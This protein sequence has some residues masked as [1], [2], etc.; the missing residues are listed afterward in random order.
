MF[1]VFCVY[2]PS[3]KP[4]E[5]QQTGHLHF[6]FFSANTPPGRARAVQ[7]LHSPCCRGCDR[8]GLLWQDK[9]FVRLLVAGAGCFQMKD[10]NSHIA[11]LIQAIVS[12]SP[13]SL[14]VSEQFILGS[15]KLGLE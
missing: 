1:I 12:A 5:K 11:Q 13:P 4:G 2:K 8:Q 15:R 3:M 7:E 9:L 14:S 10:A 6:T